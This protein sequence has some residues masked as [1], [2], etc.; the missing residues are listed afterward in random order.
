MKKI[1]FSGKIS[2]TFIEIA[3]CDYTYKHG[4]EKHQVPY[5][6]LI[7]NDEFDR[8]T[9]LDDLYNFIKT[10]GADVQKQVLKNVEKYIV[11]ITVRFED[12]KNFY[13]KLKAL[14]KE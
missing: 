8:F 10:S 11:D 9:S 14:V 13:G 1:L 5:I 7:L 2:A 4:G 6:A 3:V 12:T